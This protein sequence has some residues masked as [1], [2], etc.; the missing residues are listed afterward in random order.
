VNVVDWIIDERWI[1]FGYN[2]G[3]GQ[4]LEHCYFVPGTPKNDEF[5][6]MVAPVN[7]DG[8]SGIAAFFRIRDPGIASYIS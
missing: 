8:L 2:G 4:Y 6:I 1:V 3:F 5:D 7:V